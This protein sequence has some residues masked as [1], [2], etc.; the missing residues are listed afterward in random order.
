MSSATSAAR[1]AERMSIQRIAI[2][3]DQDLERV[4]ISTQNALNDEL[5]SVLLIKHVLRGLHSRFRRLHDDRSNVLLRF[6]Q[7]VHRAGLLLKKVRH[8]L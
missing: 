2:A 1:H 8:A 7:G 4:A 5:I 6:G 3:R